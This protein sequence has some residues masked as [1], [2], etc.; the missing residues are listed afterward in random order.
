MIISILYILP[1]TTLYYSIIPNSRYYNE[2][3]EALV[4]HEYKEIYI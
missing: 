3:I 2:H 1:R 4:E